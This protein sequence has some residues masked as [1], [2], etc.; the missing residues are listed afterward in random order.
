MNTRLHVFAALL[1]CLCFAGCDPKP[2][3]NANSSLPTAQQTI[4]LQGKVVGII[5]G[6]TIDVLLDGNVT[7]RIRLNAIDAPERGQPFGNKAKAYLSDTIGG[8][9]VVLS[10]EGVD[11]YDRQISDVYLGERNINWELV[12]NGLAWHFKKYSDDA[13]L[14]QAEV[15]AKANA[16]GLWADPRHVA[17]WDWR[18]LS[19]EERDKLR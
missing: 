14:A 19:K 6:D 16:A 11:R 18:K 5:D 7:K 2:Q 10:D 3:D 8:Q 13:S 1:L 15:D 12:R 17:P 4:G 9:I